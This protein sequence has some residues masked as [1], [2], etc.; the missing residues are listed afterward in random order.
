VQI[1]IA[2]SK[3][4]PEP[5]QTLCKIWACKEFIAKSMKTRESRDNGRSGHTY[6]LDGH[7]HMSKRMVRKIITK[8]YS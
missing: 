1:S 2:W 8:I 6:D 7:V 4:R 5:Y 3:D